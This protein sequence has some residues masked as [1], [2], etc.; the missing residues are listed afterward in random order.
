MNSLRRLLKGSKAFPL[1]VLSVLI[2]GV[3]ASAG[4][5]A[6]SISPGDIELFRNLQPRSGN[7]SIS[8]PSSLDQSRDSAF[9]SSFIAPTNRAK[10]PVSRIEADYA[11]RLG[12]AN[13]SALRQFGYDLFNQGGAS[14]VGV[15]GRIP[16]DYI[17]GVGD[18]LVIT[19]HGAT[20]GTYITRVDREGR[21]ALPDLGL[22]NAAGQQFGQFRKT[23]KER[24]KTSL[25][26]TEAYI[27][28][29]SLRQIQVYVIGEVKQPGVHKMTSQSS[30]L[31]ALAYAG[32]VLKSGSLRQI[33]VKRNGTQ[34]TYDLYEI[35]LGTAGRDLTLNDGDR[36][37]V[38][39][40]G[41][42][43]AAVGKLVRPAIYELSGK[44]E[45]AEGLMQQAGG[46]LRP[47]GYFVGLKRFEDNGR[48]SYSVLRAGSLKSALKSGDILSVQY[49]ENVVIGMV[50]L[51]GHVRAPGERPLASNPTL[52]T[53]VSDVYQLGD[54]PYLPFA[55]IETTDAK[56]YARH[57]RGINLGTI[58]AGKLDY[59]LR[60]RDRLI[61][62]S[63]MDVEFLSS[64]LVR[65]AINSPEM[66][67]S[68]CPGLNRLAKTVA[69]SGA[70]R[71]ANAK[72]W[73]TLGAQQQE[74]N[75]SE[76]KSE[77]Q[78]DK[79]PEYLLAQNEMK[80]EELND[81]QNK[82]GKPDC[83]AI[84]VNDEYLLGFLLENVVSITGAVTK[85]G[86]YP[87]T[88]EASL[89]VALSM[90]GGLSVSA[91]WSRLEVTSFRHRPG[92]ISASNR[93]YIDLNSTNPLTVGIQP[94]SSIYVANIPD[95]Q[96][97]GVIVLKGEFLRPGAYTIRKGER[98]SSIVKR[99][100]GLNDNAY[101]YGAIFTRLAVRDEQTQ[102]LRRSI[103]DLR[104]ALAAAMLNPRNVGLDVTAGIELADSLEGVE[105]PGRFV[106]EA[107]PAVLSA[108][109]ELDL[110]IETGDQLIV[111]KRPTFVS[112]AGAVLNPGTVMFN[113]S[114]SARDYIR[115]AGGYHQ[116]A[117]K[118]RVFIL[119]PNGSARPAAKG[120]WSSNKK[121][122]IPPGS[123]IVIPLESSPSDW[124]GVTGDI[125]RIFSQ[126]ALAA[127]SL[128]VINR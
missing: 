44:A 120:K 24:T 74:K 1:F 35:I 21:A 12:T 10:S 112:L 27:S 42:T 43:V 123:T 128:S 89:N 75:K 107:D 13:D 104:T 14:L 92:G 85:P 34:T 100:G 111:P 126:L 23:V 47:S 68:N 18:E 8:V 32:G 25:V 117:D 11:R 28:V 93:N 40:I 113:P 36:I 2:S 50:R 33:K 41:K 61:V 52:Q 127:A 7:G 72:R 115:A 15:T 78:Y 63:N 109:P 71:F 62:L 70:E 125:S 110:I 91:D 17:L 55:V 102:G 121:S 105:L 65:Q 19:F 46:S 53:L 54:E 73:F 3:I 39:A 67:E 31:D 82:E 20:Q 101:P 49:K 116:T 79:K 37:I 106:V 5:Q 51:A 124:R 87:M 95:D 97:A 77:S 38:P 56:T 80:S 76:A 81:A 22:L 58:L 9:Q 119:L 6:Q 83:Q 45:S 88:R 30:V 57:Y 103:R 26:G 16:E 69:D 122:S 96:E 108:R 118:K 90:A 60:D 48:Q 29:G 66:L 59:T 64:S 99:A 94:R 4:A 114:A 98:L 84:Y 86:N